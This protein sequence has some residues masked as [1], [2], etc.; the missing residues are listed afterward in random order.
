M[1][2]ESR[3]ARQEI[4]TTLNRETK[5]EVGAEDRL[6]LAADEMM[7]TTM[8]LMILMMRRRGKGMCMC[9]RGKRWNRANDQKKKK[10]KKIEARRFKKSRRQVGERVVT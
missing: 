9:G 8:M 6:P 4:Q 10:E 2:Q 1:L 3:V 5:R 7:M